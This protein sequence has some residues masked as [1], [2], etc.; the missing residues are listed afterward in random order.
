MRDLQ[1]TDRN[2]LVI[3]DTLGGGDVTL[4]YRTPTTSER[5]SYQRSLV[6]R[7]GKKVILCEA[8]TRQKFGLQI[9]TGFAPY[10]FS[11]AGEPLSA[12]PAQPGYRD[13]W[14]DLVA[15]TA[16][17]LVEVLAISVFEGARQKLTEVADLE[18][19]SAGGEEADPLPMS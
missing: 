18:I 5:V 10:S 13:D 14:K 19:V 17:D 9:L 15:Q 11:F 1:P 3:A 7:E 6:R 12:D 16:S 4:Y 8:E 2:K